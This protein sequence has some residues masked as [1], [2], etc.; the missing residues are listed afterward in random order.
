MPTYGLDTL[1]PDVRLKEIH[2]DRNGME[3]TW[4]GHAVHLLCANLSDWFEQ[5]A[6]LNYVTLDF[7]RAEKDWFTLTVQKKS[8]VSPGEDCARGKRLAAEVVRAMRN[9][10]PVKPKV[11]QLA[12]WAKC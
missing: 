11:D 3:T 10:E 9:G 12:E 8:G 5:D 2:G 7:H 6:G 1:P 4:E